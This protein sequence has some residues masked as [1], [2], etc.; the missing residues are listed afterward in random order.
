MPGSVVDKC[1]S[2]IILVADRRRKNL[3]LF[4]YLS[5]SAGR[6]CPRGPSSTFPRRRR[7][8]EA[9]ALVARE[10]H[11]VDNN[12]AGGGDAPSLAR[13]VRRRRLGRRRGD[14]RRVD[15]LVVQIVRVDR[16]NKLPAR[17][18]HVVE[19]VPAT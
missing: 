12:Y 7:C 14:V 16:S 18:L 8:D 2:V 4:T 6:C 17:R 11:V 3:A 13:H 19:V 5:L 1:N 10:A 9:P 15:V